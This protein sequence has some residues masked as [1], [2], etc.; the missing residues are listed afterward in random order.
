MAA[1]ARLRLAA[2]GCRKGRI[3]ARV[4][5][6][7]W[8]LLVRHPRDAPTPV[9]GE[10]FDLQVSDVWQAGARRWL[11]GPISGIGL[12]VAALD[13]EPLV[14]V[15]L[16][17]RGP[18]AGR[19]PASRREYE[20][21]RIPAGDPEAGGAGAETILHRAIELWAADRPRRARALVARLLRRDLRCLAAHSCLGFFAFNGSAPGGGPARARR[22]YAAGLAI[23]ELTVPAA[24]AGVLPWSRPGN[25]AFLRCLYG[26]SICLWRDGELA[27]ARAGFLRMCRLNPGDQL[28]ARVALDRLDRGTPRARPPRVAD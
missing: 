28:A 21:E 25:R 27:A 24:F 13:L 10:V 15:E 26:H 1:G 14:L 12:D 3:R 5:G 4:L 18:L 22:H 8:T 16:A 20:L 9:E 11:S 2:L 7:P 19:R 17:D 23:G 6:A